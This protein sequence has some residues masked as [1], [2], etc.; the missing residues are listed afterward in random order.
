MHVPTHV[1]S[2]WCVGSVL[3]LTPR[4]RVF[5][6]A[7]ATAADLDGI[8]YL[9]GQEAYWDYH[10]VLCHNLAFSLLLSLV[11][12][13]FSTHRLK[14]AIVYLA[15]AHLHLVLDYFG[16]GPGWPIHYGWPVVDKWAW[17]NQ[18]AW[19]FSSWQNR[20]TA[21]GLLMWVLA[22]AVVQGRTPVETL[23]PSLDRRFV[24]RLRRLVGFP[25]PMGAGFAT[26][27]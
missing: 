11:L 9:F 12:A 27:L 10:H 20:V 26:R 14:A 17:R 2:G 7:A 23:T 21:L 3:R 4:E 6:M 24:S 5:C 19:E 16:S 8:S 1:M 18:D 13:L 25:R 15:L 22:I